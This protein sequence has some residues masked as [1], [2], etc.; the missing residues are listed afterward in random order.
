MN[1]EINKSNK[2][3]R[4]LAVDDN[5]SLIGM[6]EEYFKDHEKI[7]IVNHAYNG[8][9]AIK[10]IEENKDNFDVLLLDLIMPKKDGIYV[11]EQLKK[12][13]IDKPVIVGTS[14]NADETI[15]RVSKFNPKH[16]ILKPFDMFD[17]ENKILDAVSFKLDKASKVNVYHNNLEISVTKLLHGL[18]VPSHIKGYQYIREAIGIIFERPETIGGITKEL[19]PELAE[20]F[21]TT[22]SRV[23]RA[24]RHAIEVSW[25]RG[26]WDLMEEIFG[27]SVDIDKAKPTNSE[28]IVTIADKLRLDYHKVC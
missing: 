21:D 10:V 23:E 22:V 18:G 3:V 13:K 6:L 2:I 11:L 16:F 9:D 7:K 25:N 8:L 28:F 14:F 5:E 1:K 17:L 26:N 20:K 15:A 27:H 19:Y 12:K 24:I 4:V